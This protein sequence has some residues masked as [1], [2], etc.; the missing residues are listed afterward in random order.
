[1]ESYPKN[2]REEAKA[3]V[4][5]D[6]KKEI[7]DL[8]SK[9]KGLTIE[10]I[11]RVKKNRKNEEK[12][13]DKQEI[14][15]ILED[16]PLDLN[17]LE[18]LS[19]KNKDLEELFNKV[20]N[21]ALNYSKYYL[22]LEIFKEEASQDLK[23]KKQLEKIK[24]SFLWVRR[25]SKQTINDWSKE[26]VKLGLDKKIDFPEKLG[27]KTQMKFLEGIF[28][29]MYLKENIPVDE[30]LNKDFSLDIQK[31]TTK[32]VLYRKIFKDI[33]EYQKTKH[34]KHIFSLRVSLAQTLAKS[35]LENNN[36]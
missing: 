27:F 1:M 25:L 18:S 11:L 22:K 12:L 20:K 7:I 33:V 36:A 13:N 3:K 10:D 17:S 2:N 23:T 34:F 5:E 21:S 24:K 8:G 6:R 30:E 35:F 26:V 29:S 28:L 15:K 19:T 9:V 16:L 31:V 32:S 14:N 4:I